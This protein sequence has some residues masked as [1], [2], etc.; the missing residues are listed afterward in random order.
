MPVVKP[1]SESRRRQA[2]SSL[3]VQ[4]LIR[5][6]SLMRQWDLETACAMVSAKMSEHR[7]AASLGVSAPVLRQRITRMVARVESAFPSFRFERGA[8]AQVRFGYDL[9]NEGESSNGS[10]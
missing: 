8:Q 10:H 6:V 2:G 4:A 7:A 5:L 1:W 3:Q 9:S